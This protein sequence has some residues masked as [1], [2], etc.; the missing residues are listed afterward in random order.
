MFLLVIA[1]LGAVILK[2]III[3]QLP[4]Y[5]LNKLNK[6]RQPKSV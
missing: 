2:D 6:T 5:I 1:T 4:D 3:D